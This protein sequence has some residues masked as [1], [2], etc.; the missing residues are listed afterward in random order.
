M[1]AALADR[2]AELVA[3]TSNPIDAVWTDR[4]APRPPY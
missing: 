3:V 1:T 4:P 2:E